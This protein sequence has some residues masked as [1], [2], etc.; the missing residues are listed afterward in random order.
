[1]N[2]LEKLLKL[3]T[4][5]STTNMHMFDSD[6]RLHKYVDIFEVI[7]A[8]YPVRLRLYQKR[9]DYLVA[10]ME[11]KLLKLSNRVRYI[12]GSLNGTIDLRKKTAHQVTDLLSTNKFDTI[13]GDYKYLIKMP[14]DSVT[15]ENV[16]QLMKEHAD[17]KRELEVLLATTLEQ[18]WLGELEELDRQYDIY[19]KKRETIQNVEIVTKN[20]AV[21]K[22]SKVKIV[23]KP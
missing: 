17:T 16:K 2:G 4:T 6:C 3:T 14:M 10:A 20:A 5:V 19:K 8:Y 11:A 23:R 18:I 9:K 1:V 7:D 12:Q 22:K 15:E 21:V 13:D